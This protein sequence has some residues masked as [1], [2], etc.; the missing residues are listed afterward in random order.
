[1]LKLTL[2]RKV[3]LLF[4]LSIVPAAIGIIF[5]DRLEILL[6]AIFI[7]L[8]NF[9]F[10]VKMLLKAMGDFNEAI[11]VIRKISYGD[12]SVKIDTT[13]NKELEVVDV[14]ARK[15]KDHDLYLS[16]R[17]YQTA[18]LK[19][20][21]E[22]ISTSLDARDAMEIISGSLNKVV[23]YSTV[24]YIAFEKNDQIIFKCHL[25]ESISRAFTEE[26]KKKMLDAFRALTDAPIADDNIK[27]VYFGTIFDESARDPVRSFFN[28]PMII[29]GKLVGLI[30]VAST[31][32][33]L[34]TEQEVAILY[35]IVEQAG[36]TITKIRSVLA[37]E[38]GKINSMLAAVN[39]G[40]IMVAR[41]GDLL[42]INREAERFLG[43]SG[44]ESI[45]TFDVIHA[46]YGIFDFRGA[47]DQ[48]LNS[49]Q[50][51]TFPKIKVG[52]KHYKISASPVRN[53]KDEKHA[54]VF[55]FSDVTQEEEID[56]MKSEFI[57]TT[58]HQLRTPL[59]SMKWF[60]EMMINGDTGA[61]NDKQKE[62]VTDIYNSN[63]RIIALVN[64]LLDVSRIESGKMRPE[65]T[66]TN[67]VEFINSMLVDLKAQF[68]KRSQEFSF[69][70]PESL[71][72][73]PVDPKLVWQI[74]QNLLSNAAKYTPEKGKITLALSL[75]PENIL[76]KVTDNGLGIPEF[77]KH[78]LFEKFF[79]AD[80]VNKSDGT[81][82]GLYISR[83][84][85]ETS[86]G[87][88][89]FE[90]TEGKGSIFY[91]TIPLA[92]VQPSAKVA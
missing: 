2:P 88:L 82:L 11:A 90:S 18:M 58:S 69:E 10:A 54:V 49:G 74:L 76:V 81:G 63:E 33:G 40:L 91:F 32:P 28:L 39:E 56:E 78:R 31:K 30:N 17:S 24:S 43:I 15:L 37:E 62:V 1:M 86:G 83:K 45:S 71:P 70:H 60:L 52:G 16:Q 79:R 75:E 29:G 87:K 27:T 22:R 80:N 77:Q 46:L 42:V 53:N 67:L 6:P 51:E 44:K 7:V 35:V 64:D 3:I 13:R 14:M 66:P 59:S 48:V 36:S 89:W 19:E 55:V 26:I 85:A 21:A 23:S 72:R 92:V 8:L 12:Y 38:M 5:C 20:L 4:V 47:M 68:A 9:G 25:E 61:L 73:I 34:Y 65:P 84:I 41:E 57:S 50:T